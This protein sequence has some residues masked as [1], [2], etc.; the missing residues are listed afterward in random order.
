MNHYKPLRLGAVTTIKHLMTIPGQASCRKR[1]SLYG[2]RIPDFSAMV[3]RLIA[4]EWLIVRF[5]SV[6]DQQWFTDYGS[7]Q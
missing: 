5:L 6:G 2:Q 7:D 4:K 1:S 3:N